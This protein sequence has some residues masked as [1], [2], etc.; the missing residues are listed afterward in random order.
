M[1]VDILICTYNDGI[2]N[3]PNILL[4][5]IDNLFYKV[6]FQV[7]NE[8][9][10]RIP[11]ILLNRSDVYI[12]V[13]HTKGLSNNRN[14]ALSISS[15]DICFIAD[16]DVNYTWE[17]IESVVRTFEKD[18]SLDVFV[19]KIQT[20]KGDNEY[21][22]YKTNELKIS[23]WNISKVSSIEVV[24]KRISILKNG[25]L[26]DQNFGLGGNL[27]KQGE[28][29]IF[30]GDCLR[31]GLVIRYYPYYMVKHPFVSS[32]KKINYDKDYV[33]Y[34]GAYCKRAY[35]FW[36][37]RILMFPLSI[38]QYRNY[39]GRMGYFKYLKYFMEGLNYNSVVHK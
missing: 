14:N 27:F 9:Y 25:I 28:E 8:S 22:K 7:T 15:S 30:L 39:I 2:L 37:G 6:S 4:S 31:K 36:W 13:I 12:S 29:G 20:P 38:K 18:E 35:G 5:P 3:V 10:N 32:G 19:G 26:F 21:K 16:D 11:E 34:W 24:F 17:Y 23:Y 1:T 33:M